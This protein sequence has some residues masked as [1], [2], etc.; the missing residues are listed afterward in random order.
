M[1][2]GKLPFSALTLTPNLFHL[3]ENIER[4]PERQARK[5]VLR[6]ADNRRAS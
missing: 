6:S 2:V 5:K 4:T 3:T 1:L